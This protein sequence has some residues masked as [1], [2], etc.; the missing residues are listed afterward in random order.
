MA[1]SCRSIRNVTKNHEKINSKDKIV[2]E[3]NN[4]DDEQSTM[5]EDDL[6]KFLNLGNL[7]TDTILRDVDPD[8]RPKDCPEDWV[9]LY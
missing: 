4:I 9:I 2:E 6:M 8:E 7:P 1:P 5:S 3:K